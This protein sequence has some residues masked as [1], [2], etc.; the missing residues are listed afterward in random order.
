MVRL[1]CPYR[2][3]RYEPCQLPSF[4]LGAAFRELTWLETVGGPSGPKP[5]FLAVSWSPC[6]SFG[7][8]R[9]LRPFAEALG[10]IPVSWVVG[11][12]H[13]DLVAEPL[14][15]RHMPVRAVLVLAFWASRPFWSGPDSSR[16]VQRSPLRQYECRAST[17]RWA[18]ARLSAWKR[19][20]P[21]SFRPCRSTRLRRFSPLSTLQVYCTLQPAMGFAMFLV[22]RSVAA[23]KRLGGVAPFPMAHAL[24][25]FSLPGSRAVS[26]RPVPSRCWLPLPRTFPARCRAFPVRFPGSPNLRA[27]LH[28]RIRCYCP[29]VA[30]ATS[31]VASLGLDPVRLRRCIPCIRAPKGRKR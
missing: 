10:R 6:G 8:S 3:S 19:Q 21:D 30:A 22:P 15:Q 20:P 28:Q 1:C 17:P 5:R 27:L 4:Q 18:E 26:P 9:R 23:R 16:G 31:L 13:V 2:V 24:R 12:P 25:S 11:R 7:L 29:G 14:L